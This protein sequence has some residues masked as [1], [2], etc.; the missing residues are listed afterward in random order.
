MKH[1][2]IVAFGLLFFASCGKEK[3]VNTSQKEIK[4]TKVTVAKKEKTTK[5]ESAVVLD[6]E[7]V[8]NVT[9]T[10]ND[11]MRFD[12]RK[13]KV[14]SGQKVRLTLNHSGKL[15]KK[16]MGHN[17]VILKSGVKASSFA[18][19]AASSKSND[20]IPDGTTD[21]IAHTKMIGCGESTMIEFIA[22][23]KGTYDYICSFPGHFAMM[24][25]KLIVE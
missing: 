5:K 16:I 21:V 20:Y 7:G 18:V 19:K 10:S 23:E 12:V 22:P 1:I 11:G 4:K 24:K 2:I 15:D 17:V 14:T 3:K 9:I 25:G 8:A 6:S 13:I